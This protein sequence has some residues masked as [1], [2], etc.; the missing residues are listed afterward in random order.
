MKDGIA[1]FIDRSNKARALV[2]RDSLRWDLL[3]M[4]IVV[5]VS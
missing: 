3:I 1:D 4:A 2:K 5:R